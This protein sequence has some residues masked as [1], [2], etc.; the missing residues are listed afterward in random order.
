MTLS[1]LFE[2]MA[3]NPSI[4]L[5]YF[6]AIVATSILAGIFSKGEGHKSPWTYL[7]S[8]LVYLVCVPG[9]FAITLNVYTFIFERRSIYDM[10]IYAHFLPIIAMVVTLM[11]IRRN[12][13]FDDIPGFSN[14]SALITIISV[15]M[16]L[17]WILEKTHIFV[18]SFMPFQYALIIIAALLFFLRLSFKKL[19]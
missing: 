2:L 10:N 9:I 11:I 7:Y 17:L 14:I 16:I 18:I 15:I 3:K 5:F 6:G 1:D 12:V 19:F 13:D 4:I 8:G